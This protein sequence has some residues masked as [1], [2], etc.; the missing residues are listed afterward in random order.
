MTPVVEQL[1]RARS[2]TLRRFAAEMS[3]D[4]KEEGL[5]NMRVLLVE[6]DRILSQSVELMLSA[7]GVAVHT[8]DHGE[9]GADLA[10]IY[11]YDVV[12]LGG[13]L[14]DIP[15][16]S[17][18]RTMRAAKVNTPVIVLSVPR[19]V[20]GK[21]QFFDA[22]ADDFLSKPFHKD[23]L[24]ARI[25]AVVRRSRG[26]ATSAIT[27]GD[28]KVDMPAKEVWVCGRKIHLTGREYQMMELLAM[29]SGSVLTKEAFFNQIYGGMDEPEIKI[30]DVFI[31]K[32]RKK[33]KDAGA[34]PQHIQTV[35]GRGYVLRDPAKQEVAA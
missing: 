21:V 32:L 33:L 28:I 24:L 30:V 26:H 17:A 7:E 18:L 29:R 34:D 19:E 20:G 25:Y 16:L 1:L 13:E 12:L 11:N 35:W 2:D 6:N 31:C 8:S 14:K 3:K 15:S 4:E 9:E 27:V 10:R 5:K 22:G 23:E